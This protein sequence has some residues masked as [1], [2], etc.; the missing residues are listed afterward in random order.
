MSQLKKTDRQIWQSIENESMR[1]RNTINLIASENY[2]SKAVIEAQGSALTNKYA[3][4]Y[5]DKR[6]YGGC[7]NMDNIEQ[8]AIQRVKTL[9]GAQ[10]ANVQPHSGASANLAVFFATLEP[11]DTVLGLALE[12]G[13]HLTHGFK[14]NY[15][16]RFY[17]AINYHLNP[18]TERI[19]YDEAEKLAL[20]HRPK[21]IVVGASAYSRDIDLPRF[22]RIADACKALL[23][24]DM[25]HVAG[26]VAA[27]VIPNPVPL[28]DFVTS[29][30][31][32]TLR[33]PRGGF[34][35]CSEPWAKKIDAAVFPRL[36]GG[37]LMHVIA[38]KA[39]AFHEA[40]QPD[41]KEYGKQVVKNAAAMAEVLTNKGMRVISGGTDNHLFLIDLRD[42]HITGQ[43]AEDALGRCGIVVNKNTIPF[44]P[45]QKANIA[46]GMRIGTAAITS[47]GM[48]ENEARQIAEWIFTVCQ[49]IGNIEVEKQIAQKVYHLCGKYRVPG[50]NS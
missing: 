46:F 33:G 38:A 42:H 5:P 7:Q 34:I 8:L 44:A 29:T 1:Q 17:N 45:D 15:S 22:R 39:V 4:G 25:A 10:H 2:A 30:T 27:G 43:E 28:C 11:G 31:H 40:M 36:Q 19:D 37:P 41:F 16:G 47:R 13:G 12:H 26:L 3:E 48:K 20:L 23:M 18:V 14:A 6:Y 49:N 35:L 9:F 32:K 24:C 50:I 21:L